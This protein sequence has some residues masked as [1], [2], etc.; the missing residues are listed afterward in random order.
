MF[1]IVSQTGQ[2]PAILYYTLKYKYFSNSDHSRSQGV[3]I[4]AVQ[5]S[6]GLSS[7]D[8]D[9]KISF[10]FDACVALLLPCLFVTHSHCYVLFMFVVFYV[11]FFVI[12]VILYVNFSGDKLS[13]CAVSF[14]VWNKSNCFCLEF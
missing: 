5:L 2:T 11:K 10:L 4:H 13:S 8:T 3:R 14:E 12:F 7:F 1:G 6:E 9:V